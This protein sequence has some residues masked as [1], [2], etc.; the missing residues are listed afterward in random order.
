MNIGKAV[1][2]LSE[3]LGVSILVL[4]SWWISHSLLIFIPAKYLS[5]LL[6]IVIYVG[7]Y[8]L[9]L[10]LYQKLS[11]KIFEYSFNKKYN[12]AFLCMI[13][14]FPLNFLYSIKTYNILSLSIKRKKVVKISNSKKIQK[15]FNDSN[16][17]V[18]YFALCIYAIHF[19]ITPVIK[20]FEDN[21]LSKNI[22]IDSYYFP[23][24]EWL[25]SPDNYVEE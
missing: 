10:N 2:F 6:L 22:P 17:C 18:A 24:Y 16:P 9:L 5:T 4:I 21:Y 15:Y 14:T 23:I 8:L 19:N 1:N 11:S 13:I 7:I 12:L 20:W 25:T 3:T